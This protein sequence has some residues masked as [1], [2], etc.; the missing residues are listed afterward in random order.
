MTTTKNALIHF[1]TAVETLPLLR[2]KF[3]SIATMHQ[4]H[5]DTIVE[6][7]E[8]QEYGPCDT[9]ISTTPSLWLAVKTADC[10]PLL[11]ASP[12]GVAAIHCGWR[13]LHKKLLSKTIKKLTE[14]WDLNPQEITLHI[15]PHISPK[16]YEVGAEFLSYFDD[17]YFEK[18]ENKLFLNLQKI[19]E[20]E[21]TQAGVPKE[22]ITQTDICTYADGAYHSHRLNCHQGNAE[23]TG[24]NYSLI[25]YIP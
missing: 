7:T 17:S 25:C 4:V 12:K 15:G 22:N 6:A 14:K 19:A 16:N 20:A 13:G 10:V 21:A 9:L 18:R 11:I 3:T 8:A 5:G 1:G 24:R 2:E 23:A